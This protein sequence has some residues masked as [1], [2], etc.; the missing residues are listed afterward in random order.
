[1]GIVNT[2]IYAVI[3]RTYLRGNAL[4]TVLSRRE[5]KFDFLPT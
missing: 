3:K 2:I 4:I 5:R 1:M